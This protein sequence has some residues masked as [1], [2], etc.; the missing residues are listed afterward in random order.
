M[1][2]SFVHQGAIGLMTFLRD[3]SA[4]PVV[5]QVINLPII[6]FTLSLGIISLY[7]ANQA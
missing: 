1:R 4:F 7:D 2:P 3:L 6:L 5:A